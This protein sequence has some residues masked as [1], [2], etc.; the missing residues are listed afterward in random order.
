MCRRIT[1]KG[2]PLLIWMSHS[3]LLPNGRDIDDDWFIRGIDGRLHATW[4]S[5]DG[6]MAACNPGHPGY[7][8]Y[9]KKWIRFYI[10]E[11]GCKGIFFDCLGWAFPPDFTPRPFMRY[12]GDTNLMVIRFMEEIFG[13]IRE[14]DPEAIFLGEG[15]TL[16]G[17]IHI[18]SVH[19][20]PVRSIDGL[21]PRDFF[22]HLNSYAAR[23]FVIDQ[24]PRFAPATGMTQA[25]E[26]TPGAPAK[27]RRLASLLKAKGSRNSFVHLPGDLSVMESEALLIVPELAKSDSFPEFRLP[28]AWSTTAELVEETDG[29]RIRP[30]AQGTYRNVPAGLYRMRGR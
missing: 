3:G 9:T 18:F 2:V 19:S 11:C 4:G 20:N 14:C 30:D 22:L 15:T 24:G 1:D 29:T 26:K 16:D 10:R 27:N 13:C 21:G 23:R 25:L 5:V 17:P 12:P 6:G 28:A 8:D 7:I